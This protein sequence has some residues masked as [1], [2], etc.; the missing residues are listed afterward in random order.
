LS[1]SQRA[2]HGKLDAETGPCSKFS[3]YGAWLC[4]HR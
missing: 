3:E 4:V 1:G 2:T